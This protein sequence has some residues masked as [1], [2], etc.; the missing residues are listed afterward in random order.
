[1]ELLILAYGTS[2]KHM[3][4]GRGGHTDGFWE[5]QSRKQLEEKPGMILK[6]IHYCIA[7]YFCPPNYSR[8]VSNL[9]VSLILKIF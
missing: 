6:K 8:L 1:M 2:R 9:W 7:S 4:Y 3:V 5:L